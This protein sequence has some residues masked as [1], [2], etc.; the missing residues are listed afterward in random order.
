MSKYEQLIDVCCQMLYEHPIASD[1]LNYINNRLSIGIQQKF[2]LGFFP[3]QQQLDVLINL[4]G[5]DN[6][7][8]INLLYEDYNNTEQTQRIFYSPLQNHNL[9]IPYKDV[10]GNVIAIMGR[11]ILSEEERKQ[12]GLVKYKNTIFKKSKHLFGLFEAKS[13]ILDKECVYIVEGQFDVIKAHES[14]IN[15]VVAL[16]S[17]NM[18]FEQLCLLLRYTN[19]LKVILDNDEAGESGRKRII[20]K[21][22]KYTN[23]ENLYIPNGFKD[24]DE[25]LSEEKI[26]SGGELEFYLGK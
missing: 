3:S 5:L 21:F 7:T 23:V 2:K 15:N 17:S 9:I 1:V 25:F 22:G 10:Y 12:I 18:S 20:E 13:T 16:G 19:N 4:N 6:L 26:N 8:S 14:N 24:L 11:T